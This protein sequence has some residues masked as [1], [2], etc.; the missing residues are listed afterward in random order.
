MKNAEGEVHGAQLSKKT[1]ARA[2]F[3]AVLL[4]FHDTSGPPLSLRF[5]AGTG[6]GF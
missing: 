3:F 2:A 1:K 4:K 5:S 6:R